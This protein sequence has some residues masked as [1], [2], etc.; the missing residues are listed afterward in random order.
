MS[1]TI[2]KKKEVSKNKSSKG[3]EVEIYTSIEE[4]KKEIWKRWNNKEL[5]KKI[6]KFLKNDI[7]NGFKDEPRACLA[8][9]VATPDFGFFRFLNI[10]NNLRLKGLLLEYDGDLYRSKNADKYYMGKLFFYDG[11]GKNGGNKIEVAKIIDFNKAEN[12]RFRDVKTNQGKTLSGFHRDFMKKTLSYLNCGLSEK[13]LFEDLSLWYNKNGKKSSNYMLKYLAL[14]IAHGILVE[15]YL[16]TGEEKK[17][18][19]NVIIPNIKKLN[20][21]FGFKPL[22]VKHLPKKCECVDEWCFFPRELVKFI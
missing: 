10:M 17:L 18:T 9:N 13:L 8:Y 1:E 2:D 16:L 20:E 11:R 4:A 22:I 6:E 7:P 15:D 19:E 21:I 12:K 5:R 3:S 14:F